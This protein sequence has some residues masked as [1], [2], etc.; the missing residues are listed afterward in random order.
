MPDK[1][2]NNR[3]RIEKSQVAKPSDA[4]NSDAV[5]ADDSNQKAHDQINRLS[6]LNDKHPSGLLPALHENFGISGEISKGDRSGKAA[7]SPSTTEHFSS[8]ESK[9]HQ[10]SDSESP[11]SNH[12]AKNAITSESSMHLR[13]LAEE[14]PI[15]QPVQKLREYAE[16]LPAGP[17]RNELLKLAREQAKENSEA[18]RDLYNAQTKSNPWESFQRLNPNQRNE[19]IKAFAHG[20][21]VGQNE[22]EKT[23]QKVSDSIPK[24]FANVFKGIF[25]GLQ[26][27]GKFVH[28]VYLDH[29][30]AVTTGAKVGEHIGQMLVAGIKLGD[31]AKT[32]AY[33]VQISG[34]AAKP[35]RDLALVGYALNEHWDTMPI[36]EKTERGAELIAGIG[37]AGLADKWNALAKSGKLVDALDGIAESII[38][39]SP[40]IKTNASEHIKTFVSRL[41][42]ERELATNTASGTRAIHGNVP[43][44]KDQDHI[45]QMSSRT[46]RANDWQ[47]EL[48]REVPSSRGEATA[49]RGDKDLY[50]PLNEK[51][52]KKAY[53]NADG[54]LTPA[55]PIGTYKGRSVSVAEHIEAQACRRAKE[56][57]PF[58][59]FGTKDG[60]IAKYGSD[61]VQLDLDGLRKAIAKN[62]V[63][64]IKVIEHEELVDR[65]RTSYFKRVEKIK[66][67]EYVNKDREIL[68]QGVIPKRFL[69][70]LNDYSPKSGRVK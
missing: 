22:Y 36:Q 1:T 33:E 28:D 6:H 40:S 4:T 19:V 48:A 38:D 13:A 15:L 45:L 56:Y 47:A 26:A 25:D 8:K 49:F 61:G 65:I 60:V 64:G 57:S 23:I 58:I 52:R 41:L 37:I 9:A 14:N 31:F 44:T 34:D 32:Y 20:S 2:D 17:Q 43:G 18:M 29:D 62:E 59:S 27:T 30:A 63:S 5:I 69:T 54:D 35:I 24:G 39:K 46:D 55:D 10:S 3:E 21:T 51:G 12:N 42:Q 7:R 66:L 67:L 68:V 11:R 70:I 53:I 16:N 50:S